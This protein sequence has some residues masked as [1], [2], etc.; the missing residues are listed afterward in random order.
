MVR[1]RTSASPKR[2]AIPSG[3][4][5]DRVCFKTRDCVLKILLYVNSHLP[6]IGGR[7]LVVHNLALQYVRKGHRVVVA[8]A[9]GF[10]NKSASEYEY[11]IARWPVLRK[12]P[13]MSRA[14]ALGLW[15]LGNRVDV[16]HSHSTYPCGFVAERLRWL[17]PVPHVVTP[18]GEDINVVPEIGFGQRLDPKQCWKIEM[19]V[20]N[21]DA[22][23]AISKTI[24]T[25]LIDAGAVPERLVRIP[26]GVDIG[27]FSGRNREDIG[28]R[29]ELSEDTKVIVSIGNYHP[30]KGHDVLVRAIA[31]VRRTRQDVVLVIVGRT[32]QEFCEQVRQAG[33][34]EYVRF[35]GTLPVPGPLGEEVDPL[36][37]LLRRADI[38]VSSSVDEGA[39]GLSLALL[40]AMAAGACPV[41]TDISGSRDIVSDGHNGRVV[42]AGDDQALADAMFA[43]L[44]DTTEQS[45]LSQQ[46]QRTAQAYGW[47][48][49]ADQY[50]DLYERLIAGRP[51]DSGSS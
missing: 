34:G 18:H 4:D 20:R 36:A 1:R 12:F 24:A 9:A 21:A 29:L 3:V 30:R 45:R 32:S 48:R 19:A 22:T 15:S 6:N 46:A 40:E 8:G 17:C 14:I 50:L 7:E 28:H 37:D 51:V 41:V 23:T 44:A 43:L 33:H 26:N 13:D 39:E 47:D 35:A 2:V 49:V 10:R 5:N 38:Y 31:K 27:R 25:S 16:I 11:P 42:P